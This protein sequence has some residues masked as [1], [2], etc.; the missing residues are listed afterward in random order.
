DFLAQDA[1]APTQGKKRTA[2]KAGNEV[3]LE[4][5]ESGEFVGQVFKTLNDKFVGN[6][7]FIR[8]LSGKFAADQ[9]LANASTGKRSRTAGL[10]QMEGKQQKPIPEAIAGDI[11]A[12]AKVEDLHIGD[13]VGASTNIP[14][15]PAPAFPTPMF[16]LAVEPKSRGDEQ[17][18]S[19]SLQK[20]TDEDPTFHIT[21][22]SQ[23]KEMVMTGMSQ[24]HLDVVQNR[25]KRL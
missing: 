11:V 9:Q 14:K 21:R 16:G 6:L 18:I 5:S 8:V 17:K 7:S 19:Q 25:L 2:T 20:I 10:I 3:T 13:T 4:P 22:D 15:L 23:T 24:L 1:L 12:V